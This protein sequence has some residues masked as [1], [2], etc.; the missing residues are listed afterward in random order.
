[1]KK[2]EVE[3]QLKALGWHFLRA[4]GNHDIW[5]NGVEKTQ[6]PRHNEVN[7]YTAKGILKDAAKH[8]GPKGRR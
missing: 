7:E 3:R 5:T 1:M 8:P 6:V 4:G 2:R